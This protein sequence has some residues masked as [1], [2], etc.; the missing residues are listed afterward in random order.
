MYIDGE[1]VFPLYLSELRKFHIIEGNE[2]SS[3]AVGVIYELIHKRIRERILYLIGDMP[4]T[5]KNIRMK[6]KQSY[7]TDECINPVV[8]ELKKY[9][10][11]D[12]VDYAFN[13][14]AS[15][16]DNSGKS[17]RIIEQKLYEKGISRNIIYQVMSELDTNEDNQIE[18]AIRKKGYSVEDI[19]SMD[20]SG[21]QKLYRYLLSKGFSSKDICK[22]FHIMS[23]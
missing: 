16:R 9:R 1:Y 4:R 19:S 20:Y 11:I 2:I 15:L 5:E 7:Y 13:Y 21:Q 8:E 17:R 23:E 22:Y 3:D 10:Y 6:L 18:R 12:D 14:A